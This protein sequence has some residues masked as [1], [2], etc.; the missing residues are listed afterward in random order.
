M[1]TRTRTQRTKHFRN[2]AVIG[3]ELRVLRGKEEEKHTRQNRPFVIPQ[4]ARDAASRN[5]QTQH[6]TQRARIRRF[7]NAQYFRPYVYTHI[8]ICIYI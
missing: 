8:Y 2:N 3:R 1:Y 5:G 7:S 4:S 6:K